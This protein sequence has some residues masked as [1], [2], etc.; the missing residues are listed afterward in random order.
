VAFADGASIAAAVERVIAPLGLRLDHA[1]P[2]VD[3]RLPDGSRLHAVLPPIAPDGPIVA[4]RRFTNV[5]GSLN[6]LHGMGALSPEGV[7]CLRSAVV[8]RRNILVCGGTG[9]G[10]TTL[11][12]VLS[13]EIPPGERVVTIE[14]AAE[15]ALAGHVVSLESRPANSEGAGAI[16][17]QQLVRHGLR[18][19]PD[20][21]IVGE[22]RGAEAIDMIQAMATGHAGSMSTVHAKDA[23][24][25]LWRLEVLAGGGD[26]GLAADAVRALLRSGL[27]L[28]VVMGRVGT[29]R[30]VRQIVAVEADRLEV[31]V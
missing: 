23:A 8:D 19:R 4:I 3:A 25:A 10:K 7:Q 22:V 2:V 31:I 14:D 26:S 20:R 11:L 9:T 17:M 28:V 5:V 21:I 29:S 1:S 16:S 24:E 30:V 6:A 27:D 13:G 15:L 12:N 18:L